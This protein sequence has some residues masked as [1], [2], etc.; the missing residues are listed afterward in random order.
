MKPLLLH[1]FITTRCNA[2]CAFCDIWKEPQQR[3]ARHADVI[4]NLNHA[5]RAGSR[6]VDFTGGEPLLHPDLPAF[7]ASAKR[8]GYITSV[9]TNCILFPQRCQE[10][11][12]MID[13]LHFSIDADTP[14]L[15]DAIRGCA[16]YHKVMSSI[17]IALANRLV[18]DLLFTYTERNIDAFQGVYGL[19][20]E[21]RLMVILDPVFATSG[22]DP[23]DPAVHR[24]AMKYAQRPGVYLNRAHLTL[25][26]QGGNHTLK[27]L[28]RAVDSTLVILPDNTLALPCFHHRVTMVPVKNDLAGALTGSARSEAARSQG[29][30]PFCERCHI[31]CYFDPSYTL[32]RNRMFLLS[33]AAKVKYAWYKYAVYQRPLPAG[34]GSR[35]F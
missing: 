15:H 10:L 33:L 27:P 4:G 32:L 18:P 9:T 26:A 20:R 7:L 8:L 23:L 25:R 19:A 24:R 3:D 34:K 13:L 12:G 17:D 30:Y 14:E 2:R 5:R 35:S 28:C 16:S 11:A 6:F 31:N 22:K 29:R 1:Y 21:K